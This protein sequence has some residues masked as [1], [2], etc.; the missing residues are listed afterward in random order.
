SLSINPLNHPLLNVKGLGYFNSI[1]Y[2]THNLFICNNRAGFLN[3]PFTSFI[4]EIKPFLCLNLY[5]KALA[6]ETSFIDPPYFCFISYNAFL[7]LASIV[8]SQLA[9]PF[10]VKIK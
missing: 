9:Y 3:K 10:L 4:N 8:I 2:L 5:L 6:F 7:S 1:L